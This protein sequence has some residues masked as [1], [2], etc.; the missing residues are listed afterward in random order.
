MAEQ[1]LL[2]QLL[3]GVF[4]SAL[5]G[6]QTALTKLLLNQ[7]DPGRKARFETL[8][9]T[10]AGEAQTALFG[11]L[12]EQEPIFAGLRNKPLDT[13]P[14]AAVDTTLRGI[15]P[16][17][18]RTFQETTLPNLQAAFAQAGAGSSGRL[19]GESERLFR[20]NVSEPAA[21]AAA[22]TSESARQFN[23]TQLLQRFLGSLLPQQVAA[24]IRP[25]DRD[26]LGF[27]AEQ[28]LF[29][30][31]QLPRLLQSLGLG[32]TAGGGTA[33][34]NTLASVLGTGA[35]A[36]FSK[37]MPSIFG[38]SII[39]SAGKL[40]DAFN[41]GDATKLF[42]DEE[43]AVELQGLLPPAGGGLAAALVPS[44][45]AEA[46]RNI[47]EGF[48]ES[49]FGFEAPT[50]AEGA[51]GG[52]GGFGLP[53]VPGA[54][55]NA[56]AVAAGGGGIGAG[57]GLSPA[58]AEASLGLDPAIEAALFAEAGV[59]E[60]A[61]LG[62]LMGAASSVFATIAPTLPFLALAAPTIIRAFTGNPSTAHAK[63]M[64]NVAGEFN[65]AFPATIAFVPRNEDWATFHRNTQNDL[66]L[67][68]GIT[69]EEYA[70]ILTIKDGEGIPVKDAIL[71]IPSIVEKMNSPRWKRAVED[72][73]E[74][75]VAAERE[76]IINQGA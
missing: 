49:A 30:Q 4:S 34:V 3:S 53:T 38:G 45:A 41:L 40:L 32:G 73:E 7:I 72:R 24:S 46:F 71:R 1:D 5:Q 29:D 74:E 47:P 51:A 59:S 42:E 57:V 54:V 15:T 67:N 48:L 26:I 58:L 10:Q 61:G 62:G 37:L 18:T 14:Q 11:R 70:Q 9:P 36:L 63:G 25:E 60:A 50:A 8:P 2:G 27:P 69:P 39:T 68:F 56:A 52:F 66:N 28:S 23:E 22:R 17:L 12:A 43:A 19:A 6:G 33:G 21:E 64:A 16:G 44:V 65:E 55:Q 31:T 20:T 76:R 35:S 75:R 13:T